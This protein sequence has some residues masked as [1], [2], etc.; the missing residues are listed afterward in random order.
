[1]IATFINCGAIIIGCLI[2]LVIKGGLPKRVSDLIMMAL[3]LSVLYIGISGSFEGVNTLITIISMALGALIGE[4]I[5]IDKW[6]NKLGDKIQDKF[7]SSSGKDSKIAEGFVTSSL[8]FCVGAMSI[9]GALQAGLTGN[10]ETIYAKTVLDAI[11]S[12][13]FSASLGI[14]V[15]FSSVSVLLYQ[16]GITLGAS[17]LS[18]LLSDPVVAE[19][20]ATGSLMIV[21]LSFN[22]LGMTKIK[23]ANLL[24]AILIPIIFGV[25]GLL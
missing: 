19:M 10:C 2:G 25:V 3:A 23:V 18:S 14:G 1:M 20:T 17:F 12:V 22:M 21:A 7:K 24:P 4:F 5:D 16:G 11:S 13:V 15:I 9:V 8:L 6:L